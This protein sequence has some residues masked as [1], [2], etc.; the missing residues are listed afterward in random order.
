MSKL[1]DTTFRVVRLPEPLI[2]AMKQSREAADQTN[3]EFIAKS[4][5]THLPNILE[6]LRSAGLGIAKG[7]RRAARL[8][9]STKLKT[10]ETLRTASDTVGLPAIQLLSICLNVATKSCGSAPKRRGR[11]KKSASK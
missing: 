7:K 8:P 3:Q 5:E 2:T 9:F 1:L 11:P 10:L 6:T 4:V